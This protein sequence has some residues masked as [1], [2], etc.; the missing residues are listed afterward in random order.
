MTIYVIDT[1]TTGLEPD[2][3]GVCEFAATELYQ[4]DAGGWHVGKGIAQFVDPG[5]PIPP[6]ASG[7]HDIT[8]QHVAGA[9]KL[10][11]V[12]GYLIPA[13][14]RPVVEKGTIF[15]AHNAPFDI[16]FLPMLRKAKWIDT[17]RC[18]L[19]LWP[20][21]PNHK[22]ATLRYFLNLEIPPWTLERR[23]RMRSHGALF[24]TA[25]T[26]ALLREMLKSRSVDELIALSTQPVVLRKVGFGK[27]FGTLWTDVPIDYL[28][29]A[30]GQDFDQDVAHT[31]KHELARR[32][33]A[34]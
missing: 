2:G 3:N 6:E 16:G 34:A 24:D 22:N 15:A 9:A 1:E 4:D 31:I 18:A 8:D 32:R 28:E 13:Q 10:I 23:E 25:V 30:R 26:A 7:I 12:L 5:R 29:W 21:A 19:H 14:A 20:D 33:A 27:H 11:D 17:Y